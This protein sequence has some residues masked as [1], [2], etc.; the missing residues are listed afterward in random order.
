MG[1]AVSFRPEQIDI[2]SWSYLIGL[3]LC[4][5]PDRRP[6]STPIDLPSVEL[7][8]LQMDDLLTTTL[9]PEKDQLSAVSRY[10]TP[11]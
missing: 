7:M 9:R 6:S 2:I 11:R 8:N 10:R 3:A 5:E 4:F 1:A